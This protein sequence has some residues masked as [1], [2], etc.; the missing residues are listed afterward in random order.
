MNSKV[1]RLASLLATSALGLATHTRASPPEVGDSLLLEERFEDAQFARRGWYDGAGFVLST[2][3]HI[4]GSTRSAE[5]R[6]R[7][8]GTTP[9]TGGAIRRKFTPSDSVH[10]SYWVK[11]STNYTGSNKPYHP[12]EFL[13]MTTRNGDWDG[14]AYT[15]LTGYIEQNEGTPVLALQDGQNIDETRVG[16]DL[17][18]VTENR[19]IAGCNGVLPEGQTSVDCYR[20][21]TGH[22][23]GKI[24]KAARPHFLDAS[25]SRYDGDWHHVEATFQLNG[26]V[27]GKAVADGRLAYWLDDQLLIDRTNVILRTGASPTMKW[28]QFLVAPYIGDGSP[29]EQTMW[30]DDLRITRRRALADFDADG[31]PDTWET[32]F[33]LDPRDAADATLDADGDRL[34]NLQEYQAGTDPRNPASTLRIGRVA[35]GPLDSSITFLGVAGKRYEVQRTGDLASELW[36]TVARPVA[37]DGGRIEIVDPGAA[38]QS[39]RFYRIKF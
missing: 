35:L 4:A 13:L 36:S 27:D 26:L 28:N 15:H 25:A 20:A 12:H 16:Q 11:Y 23:N 37:D 3:E 2:A 6:W 33:A 24:W 38:L 30:V 21:G 34:A 7:R 8:G 22:W 29:V 10:V 18:E 1:H 9:T 32:A 14:P 19:A 17:T 39:R 5:F 31:M